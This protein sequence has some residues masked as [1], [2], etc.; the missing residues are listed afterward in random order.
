[1]KRLLAVLTIA[2]VAVPTAGV[3]PVSA[4]GGGCHRDLHRDLRGVRVTM[5][6]NCFD[7][8]VVR[9]DPGQ[10]VTWSN[11][12]DQPH[13]VAG[14]AMKWGD[15]DEI[16]R[17]EKVSHTFREAG[18]Y[19]YYCYIH[20]GMVG[21]VVVGNGIPAG[22]SVQDAAVTKDDA[23]A[24]SVASQP[25]AAAPAPVPAAPAAQ[26]DPAPAAGDGD[27]GLAVAAMIALAGLVLVV[28]VVALARRP[29]RVTDLTAA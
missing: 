25:P 2:V 9:I 4:G 19:P 22:S 11:A 3:A 10:R 5:V 23:L 14:Q 24:P 1:V 7:P 20:P 12:S 8:T 18:T 26:A 17:G 15:Y 16:F 27:R 29:A 21:A 28:A 13:A 6:D